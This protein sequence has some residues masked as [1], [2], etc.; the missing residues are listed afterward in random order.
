VSNDFNNETER[1]RHHYEKTASKYDKRVGFAEKV[2]FGDGRG[3]VCSQARGE[4]L[5]IAVGTGLNFRHYP[6]D[7]TLTGIDLSPAMLQIAR[8]RAQELGRDV[9]LRV[10]DAQE[11]AFPDECFDTVV[12]TLSLCTIPDDRKV[13]S[14]AKRVLRPGGRLLLLEHVRSPSLPVRTVQRLLNPLFVRFEADHLMRE[15]LDHVNEEG[16]EVEWL[17]RSGWGIVE[18]LSARKL[19][20]VLT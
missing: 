8:R 7:V 17:E 2:L 20:R 9:D 10:A 14:E 15:P 1:V 13:V 11:L 19:D 16:F 5:E 18:R 6:D 3:W 4:A 12:S